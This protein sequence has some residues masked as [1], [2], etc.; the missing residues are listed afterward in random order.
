MPE[1]DPS[2][3]MPVGT[4]VRYW[5]GVR[6]GDGRV[7]RT[8]S[9]VQRLGGHTLVV[10]V[11]GESSAIAVTHVEA[12]DWLAEVKRLRSHLDEVGR[13]HNGCPN[14]KGDVFC[15]WCRIFELE[16][17][18]VDGEPESEVSTDA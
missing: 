16:N 9:I 10:W 4:S 11:E 6:E 3:Y 2:V 14:A 8:R 5:T 15:P 12:I 7:S 18:E 17:P 1:L 13:V